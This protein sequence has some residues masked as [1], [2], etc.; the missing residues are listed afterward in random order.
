MN[1][2]GLGKDD[3]FWE[4][5][6]A[7]TGLLGPLSA[8][9]SISI[10]IAYSPWFSWSRNA[11]S[12]LG[13]STRSGVAPIFNFGL[14]L[15]GVLIII[16]CVTH[17]YRKTVSSW[18]IMTM[19]G[20]FLILIAVFDEVYGKLHFIVSLLFFLTGTLGSL[21]F[22]LEKKNP[23]AITGFFISAC[24]W[25]FYYYIPKIVDVGISV[26]IS[27]PEFI[28]SIAIS[29]W[30]MWESLEDLVKHH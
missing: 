1:V 30:L 19:S 13:H 16:Y 27:V 25:I 2:F 6:F 23:L 18:F 8:F 26:G 3:G 4:K 11:L 7:A 21:V 14:T 24:V 29:A 28:S 15:A 5:A 22:Y 12:D 20:F 9:M 17:L 10:A